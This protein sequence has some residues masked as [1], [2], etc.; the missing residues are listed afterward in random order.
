MLDSTGRAGLPWLV[1]D[2]G[3]T[4]ARFGWVEDPARGVQQVRALPVADHAGPAE[5]VRAYLEGLGGTVRPLRAVA[6]RSSFLW[7]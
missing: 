2:V 6:A 7:T 4:N 1:A 5:A 3:G